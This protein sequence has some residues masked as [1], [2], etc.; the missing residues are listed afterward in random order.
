MVLRPGEGGYAEALAA[1]L[2]DAWDVVAHDPC[3]ACGCARR[4]A[5]GR[6]S[7]A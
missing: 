2:G 7:R 5:S 4:A 1:I 3:G 6:S